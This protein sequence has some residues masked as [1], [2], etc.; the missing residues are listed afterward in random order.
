MSRPRKA[1]DP[2]PP[3]PAFAVEARPKGH[4]WEVAVGCPYCGAL[5]IHLWTGPGEPIGLRVPHC[6]Q[7]GD[8]RDYWVTVDERCR[9]PEGVR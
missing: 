5:H 6:A 9:M 4:L 8:S 7:I 3:R 2:H 1:R